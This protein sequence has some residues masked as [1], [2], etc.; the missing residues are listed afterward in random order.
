MKKLLLLTAVL[1]TGLA[2]AAKK[3]AKNMGSGNTI[4]FN[5]SCP[6]GYSELVGGPYN[7]ITGEGNVF[8]CQKNGTQYTGAWPE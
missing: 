3:P 7:S 6:K 1:F 4:G 5:G 8:A 2:S